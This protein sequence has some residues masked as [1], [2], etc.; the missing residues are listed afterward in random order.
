MTT[1]LLRE[2]DTTAFM[3]TA[4]C[5]RHYRQPALYS[6]TFLIIFFDPGGSVPTSKASSMS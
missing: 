5:S 4:C 2:T 3:K 1:L 6:I